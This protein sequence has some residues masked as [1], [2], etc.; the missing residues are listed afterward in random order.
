MPL[1]NKRQDPSG[2]FI[3][4]IVSDSKAYRFKFR[5]YVNAIGVNIPAFYWGIYSAVGIEKRKS[6]SDKLVVY[7]GIDFSIEY[8]EIRVRNK[9]GIFYSNK[10]D[11]L[12]SPFIGSQFYIYKTLSFGIESHFP[13]GYTGLWAKGPDFNDGTIYTGSLSA[14][15]KPLYC[16]LICYRF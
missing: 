10:L 14:E 11:V 13:S 2:Y 7:Y 6:F 12:I 9:T 16:L 3:R 15:P 8:N 4:K 5:P 1:I